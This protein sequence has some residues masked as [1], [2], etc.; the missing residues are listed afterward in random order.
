MEVKKYSKCQ[1]NIH[2]SEG[3]ASSAATYLTTGVIYSHQEIVEEYKLNPLL[4]LYSAKEKDLQAEK[5]LHRAC[6]SR[7]H[8]QVLPQNY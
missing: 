3:S 4:F 2:G 1:L 7:P 5:S 8:A 6:K